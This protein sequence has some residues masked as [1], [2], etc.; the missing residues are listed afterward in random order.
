M[1]KVSIIIPSRNEVYLQKTAE[2]LLN[3]AEGEIEVIVV[4]DEVKPKLPKGVIN[5]HRKEVK[6]MRN[7][8]NEGAKKATGKY[9]MKC[10]AHCAFDEGFDAKL[11]ANCEENWVIVPR[12][13]AIDKANWTKHPEEIYYDFQY[14]SHPKDPN[15]TFK[16]VDWPEYSARVP[17]DQKIVD[18]MT[19]QGS[20]WFMHKKF[21]EKIG[22]L[23]EKNYGT[24]GA[25]AQEVCLKT[26]Q[27]GGKYI[28]NR[29]T[30]Y[31][32]KKKRVGKRGN[33]RGYKKPG[34]EWKK[35]RNY[36]I[37]YWVKGEGR[38][39]L[40]MVLKKFKPIP[41]WDRRWD[42][43]KT[44]RFILDKYNL[45][46]ASEYPRVIKGLNRIGLVKLW[47]E[48][49]YKVGAEI[50]VA[51]GE[52]S[53]LMFKGIP[54][55]KMYLV[56]PYYDYPGGKKYAREHPEMKKMS[57]K[58]M[59]GRD[60]VWLEEK[61]ETAFNKIP[62][63]SLDFVY[64]DGNHEYNWVMLDIILWERKVKRGG[65]ISGHDY[66]THG[67]PKH[68]RQVKKAVDDFT[69]IHHISPVYLTDTNAKVYRADRH[70]SWFWVK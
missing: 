39:T 21:F 18:L 68:I 5:I 41:G 67:Y 31:A 28:L 61:S 53:D 60:V 58:L 59:K 49:G 32:H 19:S 33:D 38:P 25:E 55:L 22:G 51:K 17:K 35:S 56:D 16:G 7:A 6:G 66:N 44:N 12:R 8:I 48:L 69:K 42:R 64:I 3:K 4:S 52:F 36:A 62:D 43:L 30:W 10:D 26:Y 63:K 40:D 45:N 11:K 9:L 15:Y 2:D 70:A 54:G 1:E 13:Y 34:N 24:M 47:K 14:I 57:H 37:K 29:N 20:C 23:D 46:Q 65:I 50:G 27:A